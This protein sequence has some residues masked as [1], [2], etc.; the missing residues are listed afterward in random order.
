M[1]IYCT[2]K[3]FP[4][5]NPTSPTYTH[6]TALKS[7]V[8]NRRAVQPSRSDRDV[9]LAGFVEAFGVPH[10]RNSLSNLSCPN[11]SS[12]LCSSEQFPR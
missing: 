8:L 1:V 12:L 7:M 3:L 4:F 5:L 9:Y 10:A 2:Q 6:S 11:R